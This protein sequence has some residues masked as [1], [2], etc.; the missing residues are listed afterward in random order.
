[1]KNIAFIF[2]CLLMTLKS[3]SQSTDRLWTESERESLLRGLEQTKNEVF[4]EIKGLTDQQWNFKE[5]SWRWSVSEIIDHLITQ[6]ES[7][8]QEIWT[9]LNQPQQP[10]F[11]EQI[12]G[13]DQVFIEYSDDPLKANAGFLSPFGKY[14][15]KDKTEFA[16][17]RIRDALFGTVKNSKND[18][19][20]HFTFRNFKFDG[21]L[22]NAEI[23]NV[24]DMHQIVITC[25][26]HTERYL[27]QPRKVKIHPNYP[28]YHFPTK[29]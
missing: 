7:Y 5:D 17:N 24:R 25:I 9:C 18:F 20:K 28:K 29:S 8:N 26:S 6:D 21:Q 1:M 23:Y 3:Y 22:T 19:R 16:Y 11:I 10:Q 13:N 27:K 12:K 15:S 2:C 4:S 14:C